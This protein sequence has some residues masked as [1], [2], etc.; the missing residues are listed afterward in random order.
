MVTCA[1]LD[2]ETEV[3]PD[4]DSDV[5]AEVPE[6]TGAASPPDVGAGAAPATAGSV[7]EVWPRGATRG[8]DGELVVGGVDV[9]RI[10]ADFGT[11][12]Y[13]VDEADFRGRCREFRAAFDGFDVHYAAKAACTVGLLRWVET[14]GLSLDVCSGGEL[15]VALRAGFPPE[16]IAMHGN[17]K[18][19]DELSRAVDAGV[20]RIVVDSAEEIDRLDAICSDIGRSQRVLVRVTTGIEAHTHEFIATS[21]EDQKFGFSI[22]SGAAEDAVRRVVGTRQLALVGI[23]SHVGSQIL[24]TGGLELA[25]ERA[26]DFLA[27]ARWIASGEGIPELDLGGGFGIAY[28]AGDLPDSPATIAASLRRTVAR[29]CAE[30]GIDPPRLAVEPGRAIAGPGG[31]TLYTVGTVK[32]LAG[33]RTYIAVDGG[34]SDNIRPAL[35]GARY[36]VTLANRRSGA[37]RRTSRV[38]GK[39]CETGDILVPD[40]D[41]PADIRPGDLLAVAATGAY[42]RSL[43]STYNHVPRPPVVSVGGGRAGLLLRRETETDLLRLDVGADGESFEAAA[44]SRPERRR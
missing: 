3:R 37:P 15:A 7:S 14:E 27:R 35:Y 39:H 2:A 22:A 38:V 19:V 16:R 28:T 20:G 23:H 24:D 30:Q 1:S 42:C 26:V 5:D 33:I 21:H 13:V 32:E 40:A 12:A 44:S 4:V 17:N 41:L 31:I 43:A 34:M 10:A 11:P 29:S 9:R 18:S 25:A 36:T 8:E 6:G